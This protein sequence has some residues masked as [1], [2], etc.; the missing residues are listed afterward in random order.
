M[1]KKNIKKIVYDILVNDEQSRCNDMYLLA[2]VIE[3]ICEV[4]PHTELLIKQFEKWYFDG[5]P[6]F[7]TVIRARRKIQENHP[8]LID[9]K[10]A[11]ARAE[12]E[13][14]FREE[15]GKSKG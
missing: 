9:K 8:E 14:E 1:R 3:E 6:N 7:N 13:A 11:E 5:F 4:K 15:Y 2:R 12:K 10:T